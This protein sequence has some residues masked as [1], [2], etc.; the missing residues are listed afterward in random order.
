MFQ[1]RKGTHHSDIQSYDTQHNN[2]QHYDTQHKG[3]FCETQ[4]KT[5]SITTLSTATNNVRHSA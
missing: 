2:N 5:L 3:L 1:W 4:H